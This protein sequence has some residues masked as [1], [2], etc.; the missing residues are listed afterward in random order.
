MKRTERTATISER[1]AKYRDLSLFQRRVRRGAQEEAANGMVVVLSFGV[2]RAWSQITCSGPPCCP[3][4]WFIETIDS[5]YVVVDSWLFLTATPDGHF[6]GDSVEIVMWPRSKR[7]ISAAAHGEPV[8]LD[9]SM[10][11][12][13]DL[14][15]QYADVR[16]Y[17]WDELPERVRSAI[18]TPN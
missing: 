14:E 16:E 13:I 2:R 4:A 9:T 12:M 7:L 3:N 1:E 8:Q 10:E 17:Q 6:P 15:P 5:E 18:A 11:A